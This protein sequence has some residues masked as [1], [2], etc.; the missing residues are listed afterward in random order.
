MKTIHRDSG[1][2][3]AAIGALL[4][5][6]FANAAVALTHGGIEAQ[7]KAGQLEQAEKQ[8]LPMDLGQRWDKS[9]DAA[10]KARAPWEAL[11]F[12][13]GNPV[14]GIFVEATF[15]KG[16]KKQPTDHSM[17]SDIVDE[18]GRKRG[19]IFYK[20][21]FYDRSAHA[22][23]ECRFGIS[24]EYPEDRTAPTTVYVKDANGVAQFKV[25]GL[26]MPDWSNRDEAK[27]RD[28]KIEEARAACLQYLKTNFP[29]HDSPLAYWD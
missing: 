2:S 21:A 9:P 13:F 3:L 18:K 5:G 16:W 19:A 27:K 20:A 22:R 10:A 6:D 17:W 1:V 24:Q 29:E 4:A 7:E 15:P 23:L 14:E 8:T 11:G 28:D 26:Q 25:T 12:K